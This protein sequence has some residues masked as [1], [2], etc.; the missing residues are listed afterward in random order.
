MWKKV[1]DTSPTQNEIK[2]RI[3]CCNVN[4][5]YS[6]RS[7]ISIDCHF[8]RK[9]W[10]H[11]RQIERP[12]LPEPEKT[13]REIED[14]K[15]WDDYMSEL[16]DVPKGVYTNIHGPATKHFIKG[17]ESLRKEIKA[18]WDLEKTHLVFLQELSI[19]LFS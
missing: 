11:W 6:Q 9:N 19:K 13:H 18:M 15:A 4:S 5:T 17:R 1:T 8:E 12:A 7:I 10:T 3:E 14:Q 16:A 2:Y